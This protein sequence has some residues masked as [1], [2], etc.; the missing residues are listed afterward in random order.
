MQTSEQ[1][2]EL[3]AALAKAQGAMRHAVKDRTNPHFRAD[4]ATLASCLD[5]CRGPLADN[6]LSVVQGLAVTDSRLVVTTRLL[7]AS[8]QWIEDALPVPI[9]KMD[10]QGLGSAATY[11]RRYG[12][13]ALLAIAQADDDG[14][15]AVS[16]GEAPEVRRMSEAQIADLCAGIDE[17]LSVDDL[18]NRVQSAL[19]IATQMADSSAHAQIRTHGLAVRAKL[20]AAKEPAHA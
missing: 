13:T 12:L 8:G 11:G 18:T 7:H 19:S 1:V 17:A 2:H 6:G 5:A 9:S 3:A 4:Y 10:A 14:E 16:R 15:V 20:K